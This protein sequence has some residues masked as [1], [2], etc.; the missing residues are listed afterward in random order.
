MN[1]SLFLRRGA[2]SPETLASICHVGKVVLFL[3]MLQFACRLQSRFMSIVYPTIRIGSNGSEPFSK[4][5]SADKLSTSQELVFPNRRLPSVV[6]TGLEALAET[7]WPATKETLAGLTDLTG[8]HRR[9]QKLHCQHD[10]VCEPEN[11]EKP[12]T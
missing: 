2:S 9:G 8:P 12:L 7:A 6:K 4:V 10:S 5:Q 1:S 11:R 3:V